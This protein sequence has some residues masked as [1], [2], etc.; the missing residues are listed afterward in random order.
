MLIPLG[1]LAASGVSA[2][3]FDL[4]ETQIL[5]S[6]QA[7]VTFSSLSSY[8][9]TYQHLQ[10]R[11]T[12]RS[13]RANTEDYPYLRMNGVTTSSYVSHQLY[14][15]GS[16]VASYANAQTTAG[17]F[18][19]VSPA[20]SATASVFSSHVVDILDAFET[21]KNK[22]IRTMGGFATRE[23]SLGSGLFLSTDA[24]SSLTIQNTL[25]GSGNLAQYSRFS[26]YGIKGA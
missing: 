16:T 17:I 23:I 18:L 21:T 2:G 13:T 4:L 7:S 8:A 10:L 1:F 24:I 11:M 20:A 25:S 19:N 3:S 6:A 9:S 5:G 14:G 15:N 12:I 26:L 22:V